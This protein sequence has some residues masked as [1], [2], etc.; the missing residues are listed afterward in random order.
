[1]TSVGPSATLTRD[2]NGKPEIFCRA[3][4]IKSLSVGDN[5]VSRHQRRESVNRSETRVRRGQVSDDKVSEWLTT[6]V[7]ST[8]AAMIQMTPGATR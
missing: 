3:A 5:M 2:D 1:V 7:T 4:L 8:G 6:M